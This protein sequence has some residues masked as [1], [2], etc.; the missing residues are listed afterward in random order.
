MSPQSDYF[1]EEMTVESH[2]TVI[3]A[4]KG[5]PFSKQFENIKTLLQLFDMVSCLDEKIKHLSGGSRRKLKVISALLGKPRFIFFDEPTI[6]VDSFSQKQLSEVLH[7]LSSEH[8]VT[9][10]VISHQL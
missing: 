1:I 2:L 9:S 5:V 7:F 10:L 6:G 3:C 4:I 8:K